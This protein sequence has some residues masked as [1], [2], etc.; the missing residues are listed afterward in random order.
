[1][2]ISNADKIVEEKWIFLR[3]HLN[4]LL[5]VTLSP[6]ENVTQKVGIALAG[7][8]IHAAL[9]VTVDKILLDMKEEA[10]IKRRLQ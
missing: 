3:E 8:I 2:P 1:M 7:E 9:V 6:S 5:F 4:D 10:E